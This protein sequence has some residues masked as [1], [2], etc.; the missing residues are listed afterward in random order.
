MD[1]K[2]KTRKLTVEQYMAEFGIK[3]KT[4]VYNQIKNGM[5]KA[6]DLNNGKAGRNTWR[7]IVDDHQAAA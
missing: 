5:I 4:T 3:S 6:I 1:T 7:I 2:N